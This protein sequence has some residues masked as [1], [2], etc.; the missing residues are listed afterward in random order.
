MTSK[1]CCLRRCQGKRGCVC[2]KKPPPPPPAPIVYAAS[3]RA[4]I[5]HRT[6]GPLSRA[7]A[8]ATGP[9]ARSSRTVSPGGPGKGRTDR[10]PGKGKSRAERS[11]AALPLRSPP[12][13]KAHPPPAS[14]PAVGDDQGGP[15]VL[16][17]IEIAAIVTE[18]EAGVRVSQAGQQVTLRYNHYRHELALGEGDALQVS[19]I[20]ELFAFDYGFKGDYKVHLRTEDE[21]VEPTPDPLRTLIT[22]RDGRIK[23]L[24]GGAT[25]FCSIEEDPAV[26]EDEALN[27]KQTY[28]APQR[29]KK[30]LG[31]SDDITAQLKQLSTE[32]LQAQGE[33]YKALLEARDLEDEL[34][35][36]R[37]T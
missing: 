32:E 9:G 20:K 26:L 15:A 1:K 22:S 16:P 8:T 34:F 19:E 31:A 28:T 11:P 6:S 35:S 37:T 24:T 14:G 3:T 29:T 4:V 23:G 2:V 17:P 12:A 18:A 30:A 5:R 27:G 33:D 36:G 21:C 10:G 7:I 13:V 25:Y